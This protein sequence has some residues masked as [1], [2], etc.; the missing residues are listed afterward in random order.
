VK[1]PELDAAAFSHR[2]RDARI[3]SGFT[4]EQAAAACRMPVPTL[5]AFL[6]R[7]NLPSASSLYKLMIGLGVSADWLLFGDGVNH[8]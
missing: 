1:S 8:G 5:E 2:L 4:V 3:R 7:Q 6:Y